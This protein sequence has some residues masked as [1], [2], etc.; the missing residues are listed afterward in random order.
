MYVTVT[1]SYHIKKVFIILNLDKKYDILYIIV[2]FVT[3]HNKGMIF[4]TE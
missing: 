1:Q 4:V 3:K 2:T